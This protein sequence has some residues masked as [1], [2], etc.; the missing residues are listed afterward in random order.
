MAKYTVI[1]GLLMKRVLLLVL[2]AALCP[3]VDAGTYAVLNNGIKLILNGDGTIDGAY[4]NGDK[5]PTQPILACNFSGFPTLTGLITGNAFSQNVRSKFSGS[6]AAT[7]T[8]SV[9]ATG[10]NAG[11]WGITGDNLTHNG[12]LAGSGSLTVRGTAGG[13][14]TDC[15]TVSWSYVAPPST[16]TTP[17]TYVT[18]LRQSGA[19]SG[20]VTLEWDAA[21]DPC[22]GVACTGVASYDIKK[23]GSTV[24]TQV[25]VLGLQSSLT[26]TN[27][28]AGT[29][30]NTCTPSGTNWTIVGAGT[31]LDGTADGNVFCN[32]PAAGAYTSVSAC[33]TSVS[34]PGPYNKAGVGIHASS[35]VD[36]AAI[37]AVVLGTNPGGVYYLQVSKRDGSGLSRS[38]IY[39]AQITLPICPQIVRTTSGFTVNTSPDGAT[40][41]PVV[42]NY[43]ISMPA[44]ALHGLVATATQAGTSTTGLLNNVNVN[45]VGK[46]SKTVTTATAGSFSVASKDVT[47][48]TAATPLSVTATPGA[49]PGGAAIRM[50]AGAYAA[51]DNQKRIDL[52]ANYQPALDFMTATCANTNIVGYQVVS[53]WKGYEGDVKGDFTAGD[54]ALTLLL[55]KAASCHK[56]VMVSVQPLLFNCWAPG[57]E[58]QTLPQYIISQYGFTYLTGPA[59]Q[60]CGGTV[61]GFTARFWQ[62]G[63]RTDYGDM[64]VHL[65]QKCE[66]HIACEMVTA[67][68]E[69]SINVENGADGFSVQALDVAYKE[70]AR[71]MR[72]ASTKVQLRIGTNDHWP[73]SMMQ[74][75]LQYMRTYYVLPG[76][77]DQRL[78]SVT[79]ADEI[80]VGL[81]EYHNT[82]VYEDLRCSN[83]PATPTCLPWTNEVQP[84][85]LDLFNP[86]ALNNLMLNGYTATS[87]RVKDPA[88]QQYTGPLYSMPSTRGIY[89]I[90]TN[91]EYTV[92]KWTNHILPLINST[93]G[94]T[95]WGT[96]PV[97]NTPCFAIYINGC[98]RTVP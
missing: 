91:S 59:P 47:G 78:D 24:D 84:P 23:N 60:L 13:N 92:Y 3:S 22:N 43:A 86:T 28:G 55:N 21:S 79:Q 96:N 15:T 9:I 37:D 89:N 8:L 67:I 36:S 76:G 61:R 18:G 95:Y 39:S 42:T 71:R 34:I 80:Y 16:D 97:T 20:T 52:V 58:N 77:P 50:R 35:A 62:V 6:S 87:Q 1:R 93:N 19:A 5:N 14:S 68:G 94:A 75:L 54:A 83:P 48:N 29:G 12:V 26:T 25:G 17:P 90:W 65:V 63:T 41:T 82:G 45:N 81:D 46:V 88:T 4:P 66:S 73:Y 49:A 31:G 57:N 7:A 64:L 27:V 40:W 38:N 70:W 30:T 98:D 32:T 10:T 53:Q 2:I 44:S 51:I 74:G 11:S 72:G 69:T 56:T 85:E 33:V